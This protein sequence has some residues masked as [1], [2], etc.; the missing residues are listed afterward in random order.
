MEEWHRQEKLRFEQELATLNTAVHLELDEERNALREERKAFESLINAK[1]KLISHV[2]NIQDDNEENIST[3]IEPAL[4]EE[5]IKHIDQNYILHELSMNIDRKLDEINMKFQIGQE[6]HEGLLDMRLGKALDELKS[7][8]NNIE[9]N[10]HSGTATGNFVKQK[11]G[12]NLLPNENMFLDPVEDFLVTKPVI[13]GFVTEHYDSEIIELPERNRESKD[14]IINKQ[15]EN[16]GSEIFQLPQTNQT[17]KRREPSICKPEYKPVLVKDYNQSKNDLATNNL[18]WNS[19]LSLFENQQNLCNLTPLAVST[20]AHTS[21]QIISQKRMIEDRVYSQLAYFGLNGEN[22]LDTDMQ[23]NREKFVVSLEEEVKSHNYNDNLYSDMHSFIV[24]QV[25]SLAGLVPA[26]EK[27]KDEL[28]PLPRKSSIRVN[29]SADT[30]NV[31]IENIKKVRMKNTLKINV[32]KRDGFEIKVPKVDK[33]KNF[34]LGRKN[35]SNS[36]AGPE[37]ENPF[38]TPLTA[39]MSSNSSTF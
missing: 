33:F 26:D 7:I 37:L 11:S 18:T 27:E 1:T 23:A 19:C 6:K 34:L 13:K 15:F 17:E 20:F 4:K 10:I 29:K 38:D 8:Q 36:N 5:K 32:P 14:C 30:K 24:A 22:I 12:Q 16:N 39:N 3:E 35:N 25:T 21:D 31:T 28:P 9:T 2:G